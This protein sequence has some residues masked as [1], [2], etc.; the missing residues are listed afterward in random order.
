MQLKIIAVKR[1]NINLSLQILILLR[2]LLLNF[3]F[4]YTGG[5]KF[6]I[7]LLNISGPF[8]EVSKTL[9]IK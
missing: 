6:S 8:T 3:I 9:T 1:R 5:A 4:V 2:N 7:S